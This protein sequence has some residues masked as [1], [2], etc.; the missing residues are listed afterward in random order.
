MNEIKVGD[1]V[2]IK[3]GGSYAEMKVSQLCGDSAVLKEI[4][5]HRG[6]GKHLLVP[7]E[8]LMLRRFPLGTAAKVIMV[9][10]KRGVE[11]S[12]VPVVADPLKK[13]L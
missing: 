4:I 11:D 8:M 9:A 6:N 12:Q 2:V 1:V 13:R 3:T 10:G 7:C 5:R